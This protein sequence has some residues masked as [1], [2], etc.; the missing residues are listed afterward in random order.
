MDELRV[1]HAADLHIDSPLTGLVEYDGA[2]VDAIRSATRTAMGSLVT[3][4]IDRNVHLVL[5][6]GDLYDGTWRDYNTGLFVVSRLAE[7]HDAGIRVVI[8][9]GNH[10]AE[11][12]LTKRLRLP[13]NTTVLSSAKPETR[14]LGDLGIAVHGQSYA[15]R[16]ITADL[17]GAYPVADRGLLNIGMLHTCFDGSLG[18]DPYAPCTLV[19]L[20]SKGYD[21]WALGH[22]HERRVVCEDPMTVFPGNLQGRHIRETGPKGA[23]LVSFVDHEPSLQ[24]LTFDIV[25]WERCSVDVSGAGSEDECLERCRDRLLDVCSTGAP[26]YA[27]RVEL[28]GRTTVSGLLR[29]GPE[30]VTN[31]VRALA[32]ALGG[33]DIWVEKVVVATTPP[34]GRPALEGQGAAGEIGRVLA[35][36]RADIPAL[37]ANEG[38]KVPQL[39]SLRAQLRS[40]G[41]AESAEALGDPAIAAALDDAAELL[42][43]LLSDAGDTAGPDA[44]AAD[45]EHEAADN[46]S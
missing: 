26:A 22:V 6:A 3:E 42:E 8:V 45:P 28:H 11:S 18:H 32:L 19:D 25:R 20:R 46:A 17:A 27:T 30:Q 35:E 39:S 21:Y 37:A 10:D 1:L 13:P 9:Y 14:I 34:A 23:T 41:T 15:T 16:S 44:A 4:A 5:I 33:T 40:A 36:L 2:P 29:S 43:T 31:E 24:P 38:A 7:L 12:Q